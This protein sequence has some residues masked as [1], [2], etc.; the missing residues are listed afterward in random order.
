MF[1]AL[2]CMLKCSGIT[3][4]ELMSEWAKCPNIPKLYTTTF[5]LKYR[6]R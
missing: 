4:Y 2:F 1:L 6:S 3:K 5:A